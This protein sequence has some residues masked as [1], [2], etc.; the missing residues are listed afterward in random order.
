M[1][2]AH[3]FNSTLGYV[4]LY[5]TPHLFPFFTPLP[6]SFPIR[7]LLHVCT[8]LQLSLRPNFR[9]SLSLRDDWR[10]GCSEGQLGFKKLS[11]CLEYINGHHTQGALM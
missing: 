9:M 6:C 10:L 4:S 3:S 11:W 1:Y 5:R 7:V 2:I 8:L